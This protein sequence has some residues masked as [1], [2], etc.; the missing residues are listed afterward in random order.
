MAIGVSAGLSN[1][2]GYVFGFAFSYMA[3]KLWTFKSEQSHGAGIPKYLISV[4]IAYGLNFAV[5]MLCVNELAINA[6]LSQIIAGFVYVV[7]SFSLLKYFA[8]KH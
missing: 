4:C 3:H 1:V 5:L 8:F 2:L 6:Y 7:V